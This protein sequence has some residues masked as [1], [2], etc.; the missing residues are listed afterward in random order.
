MIFTI[1]KIKTLIIPIEELVALT[2]MV[3]GILKTL[4]ETTI[5]P[6]SEETQTPPSLEEVIIIDT[7]KET[8][9]L[10]TL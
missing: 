6:T 4:E 9:I 10:M 1:T 5:T 7:L 8:I 2:T 3:H